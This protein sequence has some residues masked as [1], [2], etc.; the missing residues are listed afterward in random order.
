MTV[1]A[2]YRD[3]NTLP[4]RVYSFLALK[5]SIIALSEKYERLSCVSSLHTSRNRDLVRGG[6]EGAF[7]GVRPKPLFGLGSIPKTL[8]L[9]EL[10]ETTFKREKSMANFFYHLKQISC[11]M[12]KIFV[13]LCSISNL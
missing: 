10:S 2:V 1:H 7:G 3:G 5:R 9:W 6:A 12:L 4:I 13:D 11:Q 8:I